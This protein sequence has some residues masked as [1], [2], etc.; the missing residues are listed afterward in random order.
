MVIPSQIQPS[1]QMHAPAASGQPWLHPGNQGAAVGTQVQQAA[2][3]PS[4]PIS[5]S[6]YSSFHDLINPLSNRKLIE[7]LSK[8]FEP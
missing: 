1:S 2:Q 6:I 7:R 3:Q 8:M 5:V 4:A